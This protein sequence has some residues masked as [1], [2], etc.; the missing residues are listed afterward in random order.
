MFGNL[1]G[2]SVSEELRVLLKP[3]IDF[4]CFQPMNT[5]RG[6]IIKLER[7]TL[8]V[9]YR[10]IT[11]GFVIIFFCFLEGIKN[12]KQNRGNENAFDLEINVNRENSDES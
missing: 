2:Q 5:F 7:F 6:Q 12:N 1:L 10:L 11:C 3:M 9:K 4:G 8:A